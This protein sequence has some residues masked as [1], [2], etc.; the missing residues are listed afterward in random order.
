[1]WEKLIVSVPSPTGTTM[2]MDAVSEAKVT[3]FF[4]V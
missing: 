4:V 2:C 1:M 3:E